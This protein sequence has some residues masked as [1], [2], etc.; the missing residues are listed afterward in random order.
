MFFGDFLRECSNAADPK[1]VGS[2]KFVR[3][4]IQEGLDTNPAQGGGNEL[5]GQ[6]SGGPISTTPAD[7]FW[8]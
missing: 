8:V 1:V 3:A 6:F 4:L 5:V 2:L 7:G